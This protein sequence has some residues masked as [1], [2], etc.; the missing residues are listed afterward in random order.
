VR[1][2]GKF[3]RLALVAVLGLLAAGCSGI[4]T[5][6]TVSPASL[7]L[8]GLMQAD[9]APRGRMLQ[10]APDPVIVVAQVR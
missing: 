3:V 10:V 9:P 5:G 8:P 6:T 1:I 2:N 7:F 4:N